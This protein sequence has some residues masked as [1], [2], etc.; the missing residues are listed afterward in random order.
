MEQAEC[1]ET[2]TYKFQ[3]PGITQKKAYNGY[4]FAYSN[5]EKR[6]VNSRTVT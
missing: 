1:S 3:T 6:T 5:N 4:L 2:S